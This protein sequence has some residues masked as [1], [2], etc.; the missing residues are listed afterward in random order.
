MKMYLFSRYLV[1]LAVLT[2]PRIFCFPY[3]NLG[4]TNILDGGPIRPAAGWYFQEYDQW[5]RTQTFLNEHGN[6]LGGIPSPSFNVFAAIV[7]LIYQTDYKILFK[8]NL[9]FEA[10]LPLILYSRVESN[11]LHLSS[12]GSGVGDLNVGIYLQWD[13]IKHNGRELFVHRLEMDISSPI[14]KNKEPGCTINPSNG[15]FLFDPYWAA[16]LYIKKDITLSWRAHYAWTSTD[17]K[18]CLK[19]G[20]AFHVNLDFAIEPHP[21]LWLAACGYYFQQIRNDTLNGVTVPNSKERILGIGPGFV[22][23]FP[24]DLEIFWYV[25]GETLARNRSQGL[26]LILRFVKYF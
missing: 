12:S 1:L 5:Y 3:V 7:Q 8:G 20:D 23:F 21:K 24:K 25:Y 4:F 22:Y 14:G 11:P 18:I 6:L 13:P 2:T 9:G 15:V 19:Y 17:K 10:H 16:T 26:S